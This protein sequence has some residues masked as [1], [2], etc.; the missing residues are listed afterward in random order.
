MHQGIDIVKCFDDEWKVNVL[1][2]DELANYYR[3]L[4]PKYYKVAKQKY[5][6]HITLVRREKII[7]KSMI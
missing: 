3:S 4:I 1:I 6:T 2:D 5:Q 7:N